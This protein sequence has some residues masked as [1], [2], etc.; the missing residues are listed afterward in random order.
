M[1][2]RGSLFTFNRFAMQQ[3]LPSG[4]DREQGIS[5][6]EVAPSNLHMTGGRS[7]NRVKDK[8][9]RKNDRTRKTVRRT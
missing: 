9:V 8:G 3:R 6:L 4:V 2:H 5:S 7:N 1:Y